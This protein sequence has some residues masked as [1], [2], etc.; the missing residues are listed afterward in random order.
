MSI[1][2]CA[3]FCQVSPDAER[4]AGFVRIA[5]ALSL[6]IA[7]SGCLHVATYAQPA[8]I[9]RHGAELRV[10]G[11]ARVEVEEGGTVAVGVDDVVQVIVPG[12]E[13]SHLWGLVHTGRPD[14]A[15]AITLG[16]LVAGC[17]AD[18]RGPDCLAGK[19][20]GLLRV[21]H[22]TRVDAKRIA[23][24]LFGAA[25]TTGAVTCLVVCSHPGVHAYVGT[26]IGVLVMLVP[27]SGTF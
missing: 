12:T 9:A 16:N 17:D 13:R 8:M 25:A 10:T 14:I 26:G 18:A 2:A 22:R 20:R 15:Q 5:L 27:L 21:G 6:G 4:Y 19:A 24:G 11:A 1:G 3:R 23:V 7:A